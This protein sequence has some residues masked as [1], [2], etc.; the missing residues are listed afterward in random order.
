M[1]ATICDTTHALLQSGDAPI[2]LVEFFDYACG[3]CQQFKPVL[4]KVAEAHGDKL[5]VYYMMYPTGK[6]VDSK[7]AGQAAIAA[8]RQAKFKEMHALLFSRSP[9]HNREA[10]MLYAKELGL[11][12]AKFTKDYEEAAAQV[13]SDGAQGEKVGVHGTPTVFFNERRYT[14]LLNARYLGMW[15][16]EEVAVNR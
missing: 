10:V 7:S 16:E 8:A 13:A 9:A 5:V 1:V 15:I 11:D 14:G 6:W 12:L 3:V 4:D 2:R